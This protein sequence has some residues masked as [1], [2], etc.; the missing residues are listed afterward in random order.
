MMSKYVDGVY[1][2][3]GLIR[4]WLSL[5]FD[6]H[7]MVEDIRVYLLGVEELCS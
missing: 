7:G 5:R 6:G 1:D 2:I 3:T 4:Q